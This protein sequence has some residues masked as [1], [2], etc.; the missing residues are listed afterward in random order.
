MGAS[1]SAGF[2]P[3][4][5]AVPSSTACPGRSLGRRSGLSLSYADDGAIDDSDP[6]RAALL[7]FLLLRRRF[8]DRRAV[9]WDASSPPLRPRFFDR[10]RRSCR[11]PSLAGD[12]ETLGSCSSSR[13]WRTRDLALFFKRFTLSSFP[14]TD[15]SMPR[16]A[17]V[18]RLCSHQALGTTKTSSTAWP[19]DSESGATWKTS[20]TWPS[21]PIWLPSW[22]NM[23]SSFSTFIFR[24][25]RSSTGRSDAVVG[26]AKVFCASVTAPFWRRTLMCTFDGSAPVDS[27]MASPTHLWKA[28]DAACV[29]AGDSL[30]ASAPSRLGMLASGRRRTTFTR[31]LTKERVSAMSMIAPSWDRLNT[32]CTRRRML[33]KSD[34]PMTSSRAL[35]QSFR[36]SRC[37]FARASQSTSPWLSL[38]LS[39]RR[40]GGGVRAC[41]SASMPRSARMSFV[42]LSRKRERMERYWSLLR[43]MERM[44]SSP[45]MASWR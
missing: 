12:S 19:A 35:T 32:G 6:E 43:K 23:C 26:T 40:G 9:P 18:R 2:G 13:C 34:S 20:R 14:R 17:S 28:S 16:R 1:A 29:I 15:V 21:S 27:G 37:S 45:R 3:I 4:D 5:D 39:L 30:D 31:S 36:V 7:P 8:R 24:L 41:S 10:S 42:P 33:L 22:R 25:M 44:L 38:P 11:R